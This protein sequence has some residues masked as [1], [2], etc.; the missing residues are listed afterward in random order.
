M[1][2]DVSG[3]VDYLKIDSIN[4]I[5]WSNKGIFGLLVGINYPGKVKIKW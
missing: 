1:D 2:G 3:F 4:N 5:E